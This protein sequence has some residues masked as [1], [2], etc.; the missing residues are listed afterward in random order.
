M[1]WSEQRFDLDS[2][3]IWP[4]LNDTRS[5]AI[6]QRYEHSTTYDEKLTFVSFQSADNKTSE[7]FCSSVIM[8]P[9]RVDGRG[10]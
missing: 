3:A 9:P 5:T 4:L 1:R 2:T 7:A 8:P 10:Y 6:R